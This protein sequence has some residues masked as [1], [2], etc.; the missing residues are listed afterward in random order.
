MGE[1]FSEDV[2]DRIDI[3]LPLTEEEQRTYGKEIAKKV[4]EAQIKK[5]E[6]AMYA[7]KEKQ[8]IEDLLNEAQQLS[9]LLGQG[10]CMR[11]VDARKEETKDATIWFYPIDSNTVVRKFDKNDGMIN[12]TMT[13]DMILKKG[14]EDEQQF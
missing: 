14:E 10:E 11:N 3:V 13:T 7:K 6:L 4:I 12:E 1:L 5:A 2:I 9:H 8:V